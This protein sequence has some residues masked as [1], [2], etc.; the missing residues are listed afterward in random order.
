[1]YADDETRRRRQHLVGRTLGA[2]SEQVLRTAACTRGLILFDFSDLISTSELHPERLFNYLIL[3]KSGPTIP[4][5][6]QCA[7]QKGVEKVRE[8]RHSKQGLPGKG[9]PHPEYD[10]RRRRDE[11]KEATFGR[12][13]LG[14][15]LRTS[16]T[17][18][19]VHPRSYLIRF[20]DSI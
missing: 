19:R 7:A 4:S 20:I 13:N 2:F 11:T 10:V 12:T 18:R 15:F 1:M 17:H 5:T 14:R 8:A 16:S 9:F 6:P 3:D